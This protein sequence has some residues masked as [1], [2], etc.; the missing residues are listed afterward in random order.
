MIVS[1]LMYLAVLYIEKML[2]KEW[3]KSALIMGADLYFLKLSINRQ[4][5]ND[6]YYSLLYILMQYNQIIVKL[7]PIW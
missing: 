7:S 3:R 1:Y 6:K 2:I 5:R 4:I